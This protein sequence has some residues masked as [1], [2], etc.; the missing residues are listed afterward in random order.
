MPKHPELKRE[1]KARCRGGLAVGEP[2]IRRWVLFRVIDALQT[3]CYKRAVIFPVASMSLF[4][5]PEPLPSLRFA[6]MTL[7]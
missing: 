2:W 1:K 5:C 6:R 7:A 4:G 3:G